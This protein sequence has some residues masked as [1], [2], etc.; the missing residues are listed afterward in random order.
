[1]VDNFIV[2]SF[3]E[4]LFLFGFWS[5]LCFMVGFVVSMFVEW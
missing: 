4:T 5:F 3:Y 1:M 2:F